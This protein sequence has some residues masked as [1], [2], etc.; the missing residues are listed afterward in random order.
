MLRI[1]LDFGGDDITE[2]LHGMLKE[3]DFPYP[4]ADMSRLSDLNVM[5]DLKARVSTLLEV[6]PFRGTP[7][8]GDML[9]LCEGRSWE[10]DA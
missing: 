10:Q 5:D 4:G 1:V 2:F 9:T 8:A 6:R 7:K 3:I